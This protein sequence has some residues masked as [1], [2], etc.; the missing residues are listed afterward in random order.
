MLAGSEIRV[1]KRGAFT[2]AE[3]Q[4]KHMELL[5][6]IGQQGE[7]GK[8]LATQYART[9]DE[10]NGK[11][12]L[13]GQDM[14]PGMARALSD[15]LRS[16]MCELVSVDLRSNL[17]AD[18]GAA[19]LAEAFGHDGCPT[20]AELDLSSNRITDAVRPPANHSSACA[21]LWGQVVHM[22]NRAVSGAAG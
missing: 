12:D 22:T 19:A 11:L 14:G 6:T 20:L 21:C 4:A 18:K 16:G 2:A 15:A 1:N 7:A 10:G 9:L 13:F 3:I 8:I 5:Q 17:I